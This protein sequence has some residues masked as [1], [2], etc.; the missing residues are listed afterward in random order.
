L[1]SGLAG[2]VSSAVASVRGAERASDLNRLRGIAL[3]RPT[4]TRAVVVPDVLIEHVD[5]V[6]F[7]SRNDAIRALA[8]DAAESQEGQVTLSC[9]T[10][11]PAESID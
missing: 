8:A 5:Y 6:R 1:I 2:H 9:A 3:D 11:C 10:W 4:A 7:A